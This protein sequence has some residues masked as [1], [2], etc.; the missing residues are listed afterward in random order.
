MPAPIVRDDSETFVQE[1]HHLGIP[2]VRTQ[3]PTVMEDQWLSL[4]Q[5]SV[6]NIGAV[7]DFEHAH[8]VTTLAQLEGWKRRE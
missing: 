5:I 4:A 2:V 6:K 1:E 8:E 3:R 7:F